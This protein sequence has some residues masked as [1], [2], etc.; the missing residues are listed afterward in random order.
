MQ[1]NVGKELAA[2]QRMTTKELKAKY[3]E[4]YGEQA[5]TWNRDWLLKRIAWRLQAMAEGDLSERA[6]RHAAE[7]ANDADLRLNPPRTNCV[8][9]TADAAARTVTAVLPD[10][11]D[12]RLPPP[13]SVITREYKG[14]VV[15]VRVLADGFEFQGEVYKTLSAV[16]KSITGSH[17]NGFAFFRL[18]KE[19]A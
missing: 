14:G 10:T 16:A 11:A 5:S 3:V 8:A 15:Q 13:G 6:K 1:I 18:G 2:L 7:L 4:V 12:R 9:E 17:C 19:V